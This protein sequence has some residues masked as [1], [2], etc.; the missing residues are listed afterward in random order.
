MIFAIKQ[1]GPLHSALEKHDVHL[2][3]STTGWMMWNHMVNHLCLGI[4]LLVYDGNPLVPNRLILFN[5]IERY[6]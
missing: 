1:G 6:R 4:T 3:I 5:F 2:Q